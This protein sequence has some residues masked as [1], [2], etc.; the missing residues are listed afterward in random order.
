MLYKSPMQE[1][2]VLGKRYYFWDFHQ[3]LLK[4]YTVTVALNPVPGEC[5]KYVSGTFLISNDINMFP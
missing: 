2:I 5:C 3:A 4:P 1:S